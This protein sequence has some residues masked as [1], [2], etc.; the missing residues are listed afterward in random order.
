MRVFELIERYCLGRSVGAYR[1]L[2]MRYTTGPQAAIFPV[3]IGVGPHPF[4]FRTRKLSLLPPMV[5]RAQV[6]GRVGH[7]RE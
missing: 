6:R 5:L 2:I 3:V 7:C 4:P 1:V